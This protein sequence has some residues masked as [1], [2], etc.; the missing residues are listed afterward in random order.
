MKRRHYLILLAIFVLAV[1]LRSIGLQTREIIYDD[2]FSIFL[3]QQRLADIVSGTAADTMPPLYYFV[4]HYWMLLFGNG[5]A[6]LRILSILFSITTIIVFFDLSRLMFGVGAGL[7]TAFFAAI[8]PIQIY[9]AQD[10]RMYALLE[11]GQAIYFWCFYGMFVKPKNNRSSVGWWIGLILAGTATLYTHNL[12]I[13]GLSIA[14]FY[15]LFHRKWKDLLRLM[16]GQVGI[17]LLA[18]PWLVMVPGQI[19]KVQT[20]F[21]TPRPGLVEVLQAVMMFVVNLPLQGV[22]LVLA[23]VFSVQ[24]LIMIVIETTRGLRDSHE[25]RYFALIAFLLPGILF[26]ISYLM[27][28][29][30]VP[31]GFLISSMAYYALAGWIVARG[32]R[33]GIGIVLGV[34]FVAAVAISLPS[35]YTFQQFPRSAYREATTYLSNH[36]KDNQL[37]LHDN[38]LSMFPSHYYAPELEQQFMADQPGSTNDT[39]AVA[40]QEAIGLYPKTNLEKVISEYNTVYFV[41]FKEAIDEYLLE[42][43]RNHPILE[44]LEQD[45]K[46][47]EQTFFSDL[48]VY[49]FSK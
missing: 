45:F 1:G 48:G 10:M 25:I 31:R 24:I 8:S 26:A 29:V 6:A 42:G 11:L 18:I 3:S 12:A 5:L 41:V 4:L 36:V 17:M 13:F 37:I 32:S 16:A 49:V 43:E 27:R 14:N 30:F 33:R 38:K 47:E 35:F 19:D 34:V 44:R 22:L 15:L 20:A 7:W 40:S 28:P 2:A 9:H 46:L 23:A 39:Y 21:W